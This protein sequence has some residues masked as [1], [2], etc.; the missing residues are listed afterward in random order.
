MAKTGGAT[1]KAPAGQGSSPFVPQT[2]GHIMAA[3]IVRR[4]IAD[5]AD[6]R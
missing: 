2:A 3:W 6:K 4:I 5:A 1:G